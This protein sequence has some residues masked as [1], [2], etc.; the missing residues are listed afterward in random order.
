MAAHDGLNTIFLRPPNSPLFFPLASSS[1]MLSRSSVPPLRREASPMPN[2]GRTMPGLE[3]EVGERPPP[4][5]PPA[6]ISASPST[7]TPEG[8]WKRTRRDVLPGELGAVWLEVLLMRL[9]PERPLGGCGRK[10]PAGGLW[11]P[12]LGLC[13]SLVVRRAS[14]TGSA[15]GDVGP[16]LRCSADCRPTA[17][18]PMGEPFIERDADADT[19]SGERCTPD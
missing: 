8:G 9:G 19:L 14:S 7:A 1:N 17:L 16:T 15:S 10:P 2:E 6:T 3:G 11:G 5:L 12:R 18:M 13:G 4:T